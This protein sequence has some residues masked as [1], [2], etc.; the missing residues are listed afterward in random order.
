MI[1]FSARN[2]ILHFL[3]AFIQ[4]LP[5]S[6]TRRESP[7]DA[8]NEQAMKPTHQKIWS[9]IQRL[10]WNKITAIITWWRVSFI[11]V[12]WITPLTAITDIVV[13]AF[14]PSGE[15]FIPVVAIFAVTD[16]RLGE[17]GH[18]F[19]YS[20]NLSNG[21]LSIPMKWFSRKIAGQLFPEGVSINRSYCHLSAPP[22]F[23]SP[24][25]RPRPSWEPC[26][27]GNNCIHLHDI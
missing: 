22:I 16:C 13:Q 3:L 6:Q 7:H 9:I 24:C 14:S 19:D 18:T 8:P 11:S 26:S 4:A 20:A 15:F 1:L 2:T 12:F 27:T 10:L 25:P 23:P 21:N 17:S 5:A